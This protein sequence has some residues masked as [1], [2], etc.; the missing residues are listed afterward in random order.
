M[1]RMSDSATPQVL[2]PA[3]DGGKR[4]VRTAP[5]AD[6]P[7]LAELESSCFPPAE[8]ATYDQ[9]VDRLSHYGDH[10]WLL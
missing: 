8:A 2:V 9:F 10:F 6:T 7:A 3:T 5:L 1:A 4:T